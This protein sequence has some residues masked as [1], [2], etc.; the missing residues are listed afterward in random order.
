MFK[1]TQIKLLI[2]RVRKERKH[3]EIP[4]R[5][6]LSMAS[7]VCELVRSWSMYTRTHELHNSL[8]NMT[9]QQCLGLTHLDKSYLQDE[10]QYAYSSITR[11]KSGL[12]HILS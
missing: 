3:R 6:K 8:S 5:L 2:R 4:I 12:E 11:Y 9:M 10:L 7:K 1:I